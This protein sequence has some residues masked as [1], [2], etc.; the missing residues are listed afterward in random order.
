[1]ARRQSS[2]CP[3]VAV[4]AL[5]SLYFPEVFVFAAFLFSLLFFFSYPFFNLSIVCTFII[6]CLYSSTGLFNS[7]C[8]VFGEPKT[9]FSLVYYASL[10]S[11]TFKY[12]RTN[13]PTANF[14]Y[15]AYHY[16]YHHCTVTY[17][18]EHRRRQKHYLFHDMYLLL[19]T[20]C[21]IPRCQELSVKA[22]KSTAWSDIVDI[23]TIDDV[24]TK[25]GSSQ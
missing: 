10:P 9:C 7:R 8:L 14:F 17:Y 6:M 1:M 22:L 18:Y 21:K 5:L 4:P 11:K 19:K 16:H 20:T 25:K 3:L 23:H 24:L 2:I 13:E 12:A 15:A